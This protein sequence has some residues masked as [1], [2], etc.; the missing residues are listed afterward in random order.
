MNQSSIHNSADLCLL[1]RFLGVLVF[2]PNWQQPVENSTMNTQDLG[3][4][5]LHLLGSCG[6][7]LTEHCSRTLD[8]LFV[9]ELVSMSKWD[10]QI[11]RSPIY[12]QLLQR[13]RGIQLQVGRN[14]NRIVCLWIEMFFD[15]FSDVSVAS[16]N[17][18]LSFELD[19]CLTL[20]WPNHFDSRVERYVQ[21]LHHITTTTGVFEEIQTVSYRTIIFFLQELGSVAVNKTDPALTSLSS[22]DDFHSKLGDS[23]F[24]PTLYFE[25]NL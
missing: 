17:D 5:S 7:L 20:Q 3:L 14:K 9:I 19:E 13:L 23:F 6:L 15:K 25:T 1:G 18:A 16:V 2:S 22:P 10:T 4:D 24:S 12:L 11:L 21:A 8:V